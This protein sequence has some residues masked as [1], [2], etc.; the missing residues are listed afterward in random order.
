MST[1]YT[2]LKTRI[3]EIEKEILQNTLEEDF[4]LFWRLVPKTSLALGLS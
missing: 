4:F 2:G 1:T 3:L